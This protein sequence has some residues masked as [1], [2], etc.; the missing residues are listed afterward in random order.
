M[1]RSAEALRWP[2]LVFIR[3]AH[4]LRG[5]VA[6]AALADVPAQTSPF[7]CSTTPNSQ[8]L[9]SSTVGIWVASVAHMTFGASVMIRPTCSF[10]GPLVRRCGES[11]LFADSSPA[12]FRCG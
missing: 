1:P 8:T 9:P 7:Q 3:H 6:I 2:L 10:G 12:G 5:G 11:R 4:G